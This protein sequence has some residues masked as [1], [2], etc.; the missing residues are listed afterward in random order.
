MSSNLITIISIIVAVVATGF[1]GLVVFGVN[2]RFLMHRLD[3][4]S[5]RQH[6]I[7][8]LTRREYYERK[9]PFAKEAEEETIETI[10]RDKEQRFSNVSGVSFHFVDKDEVE[11]FYNDTFREPT[12]ESLIAEVTGEISAETKGGLPKVLESKIG[13][14]DIS[15][16]VSTLKLPDTSLAGMFVKYQTE[17]IRRREVTLGLE[18]LDVELKELQRFDASIKNLDEVYDFA[19]DQGAVE[20]H[21]TVLRAKAAEK[22]LARLESAAGWVLIEGKFLIGKNEN[23][24]SCTL[25]HPVNEF[26]AKGATPLTISMFLPGDRIEQRYSG[27]YEQSVQKVIPL[28]V[29]GK[30]WQ[31]VDRDAGVWELQITPLAVY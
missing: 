17:V 11:G 24:Y 4:R 18:E 6:E 1:A 5:Q 29:F 31:P 27:N 3:L 23:L 7:E 14:R 2:R 19:V 21:K 12:I 15:K 22:T 26:L 25:R 8:L 28:R 10:I 30:V 13:G 16:W 9:Y 20:N